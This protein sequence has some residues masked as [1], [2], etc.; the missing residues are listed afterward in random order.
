MVGVGVTTDHGDWGPL[1][2]IQRAAPE[3]NEDA[4]IMSVCG[5]VLFWCKFVR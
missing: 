3:W 4:D 2:T 1:E 5:F